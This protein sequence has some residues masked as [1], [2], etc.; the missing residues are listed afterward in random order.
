MP[1]LAWRKSA[2]RAQDLTGSA[3]TI[4]VSTID[5]RVMKVWYQVGDYLYIRKETF[6][7]SPELLL[8]DDSLV[9]VDY[10]KAVNRL[11]TDKDAMRDADSLQPFNVPANTVKQCWMTVQVPSEAVAGEYSG[12]IRV[13][14]D[15]ETAIDMP[16][17]LYVQTIDFDEPNLICSVYYRGK[18]GVDEPTCTWTRRPMSR[19]L[20]NSRICSLTA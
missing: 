8:K 16:V 13:Q 9:Y 12:T 10:E 4:P 14:P 3:G 7:F 17:R 2:W 15:D 1:Q 5:L 6:R 19:C 20:W 11:K 18:L